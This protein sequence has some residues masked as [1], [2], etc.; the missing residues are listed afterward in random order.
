MSKPIDIPN[1]KSG[2]FFSTWTWMSQNKDDETLFDIQD[3][4]S[5]EPKPDNDE[6]ILSEKEIDNIMEKSDESSDEN[7]ILKIHIILNMMNI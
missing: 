3:I 6:N 7:E 5:E 4:S 1:A 2:G